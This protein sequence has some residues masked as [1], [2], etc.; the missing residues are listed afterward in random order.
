MV[1]PLIR[2]LGKERCPSVDFMLGVIVVA[3]VLISAVLISAFFVWED[4]L[5]EPLPVA[6]LICPQ[7]IDLETE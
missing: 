2:R 4:F 1:H 3:A 5:G 7:I 6:D